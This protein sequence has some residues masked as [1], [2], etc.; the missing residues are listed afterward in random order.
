MDWNYENHLQCHKSLWSLIVTGTD[1]LNFS[2]WLVIARSYHYTTSPI[3]HSGEPTVLAVFISQQAIASGA[4]PGGAFGVWGPPP[5]P[6][7]IREAKGMM[8]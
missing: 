7:H 2:L 5:P 8:C 1:S 6:Q 3:P 4:D